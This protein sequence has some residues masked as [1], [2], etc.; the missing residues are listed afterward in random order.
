MTRAHFATTIWRSSFRLFPHFLS[1]SSFFFLPL[2][3]YFLPSLPSFCPSSLPSLFCSSS[4]SSPTS[5]PPSL[6]PSLHPCLFSF[7]SRPLSFCHLRVHYSTLING[8]LFLFG[9]SNRNAEFFNDSHLFNTGLARCFVP[10]YRTQSHKH[11]HAYPF[12]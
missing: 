11:T 10:R 4:P 12:L 5:L 2:S 8:T 1:F 3:V 6:L 7:R 9:G